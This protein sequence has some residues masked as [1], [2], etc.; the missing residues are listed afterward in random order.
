MPNQQ[1]KSSVPWRCRREE[2]LRA[3]A[4]YDDLIK[5]GYMPAASRPS[6]SVIVGGRMNRAPN[7]SRE[8]GLYLLKGVAS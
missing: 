1:A 7:K 5:E 2:Y 3:A 6:W 4:R 8:I